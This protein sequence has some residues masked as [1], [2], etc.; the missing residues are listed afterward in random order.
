MKRIFVD[1][2]MI[3]IYW[4]HWKVQMSY[5]MTPKF[6]AE[7]TLKNSTDSSVNEVPIYHKIFYY[8]N[9]IFLLGLDAVLLAKFIELCTSS[10]TTTNQFLLSF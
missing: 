9:R 2:S 10:T 1:E 6:F 3:E 4:Q 7:D 8:K 5:R